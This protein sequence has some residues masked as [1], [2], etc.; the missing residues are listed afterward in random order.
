MSWHRFT[1]QLREY[2]TFTRKERNG[3]CV[4]LILLLLS[5]GA[6]IYT[7]YYMKP[8]PHPDISAFRNEILAMMKDSAVAEVESQPCWSAKP[9]GIFP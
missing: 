8:I 7:R 4:L 6:L 2:F 1:E 5:Q 9:G 3:I